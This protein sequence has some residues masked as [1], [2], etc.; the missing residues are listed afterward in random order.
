MQQSYTLTVIL[1]LLLHFAHSSNFKGKGATGHDT[2]KKSCA[3]AA[4]GLKGRHAPDQ[5]TPY[6]VITIMKELKWAILGPGR[7]AAEFADAIHAAGGT[8][9]AAG[10]RNLGRAKAFTEQHH[11]EK[12]YGSYDE[13]L[14][15]PD[16]D[17]IYLSTPHSSHYAYLLKSLRHG[18]HVLCEKAITVSSRQL[19]PVVRLAEE[20]GLIVAEA[21]TIFHMPLYRKL[22]E[23][24]NSGKIGTVKMVNVTFGSLK[25]YDVRNRFFSK[26][27]A[28]GALLDIGTYALSFVRSFLSSQPDQVLTAVKKFETGV[29]ESSGIILKNKD[30]EMATVTLTMRAK[31]PKRGIVTGDRAYI[32]VDNF[33]RA[34]QATLTYPDGK[35]ETIEA[36]STAH[37]MVYEFNDMN[38]AV[39]GER[40]EKTL[41]LTRDVVDI[42]TQVRDQWGIRYPFE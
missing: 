37:A 6:E 18:K 8:I 30:H 40:V 31:L 27:L 2:L 34:D 42:M 20:K 4:A 3:P 14:A 12:A 7:I 13:M 36:G 23:I 32:T 22:R 17:V 21:M 16:I 33:P 39:R 26:D 10:S 35:V 19:D 1:H 38:A 11:I 41:P 28:G 15:D 9:Y 5:K 25:P 29:D 24:I